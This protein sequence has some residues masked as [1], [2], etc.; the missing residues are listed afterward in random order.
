MEI[1][2][3]AL[4]AFGSLFLL[5]GSLG[6]ARFE[7]VY[8]R[9]QFSSKALTFGLCFFIAGAALVTPGDEVL[10]KAALAILFQFL[11]APIA[12]T[13]I[14]QAAIENGIKPH[15]L[16]TPE[17]YEDLKE[18]LTEEPGAVDSPKSN[19]PPIPG[20]ADR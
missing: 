17:A 9:I 7:D 11:T 19:S 13:V 15:Q 6:V 12:A 10:W 14:A 3:I 20:E 18:I 8:L 16:E 1:A 4:M 2:A 5:A